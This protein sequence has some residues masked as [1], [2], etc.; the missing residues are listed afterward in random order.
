MQ[1]LWTPEQA[2]E[3][4][5]IHAKT[6]IRMARQ[7]ELPGLRIGR[8]W[9]FRNSDLESWAAARVHSPRQPETE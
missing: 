8:H 4:L 9:R 1:A 7:G 2:G 3:Y 6:A 5:R